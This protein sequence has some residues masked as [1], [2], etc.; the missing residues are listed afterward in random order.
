MSS[1]D[2]KLRGTFGSS[3][4]SATLSTVIRPRDARASV[5]ARSSARRPPGDPSYPTRI[6]RTRG[7][8][9]SMS[10]PVCPP[11]SSGAIACC[12]C[13]RCWA[14]SRPVARP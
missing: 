12:C 11:P 2:P 14:S 1:S 10:E 8:V 7:S 4:M 3:G 6:R 5:I 9:A 13:A